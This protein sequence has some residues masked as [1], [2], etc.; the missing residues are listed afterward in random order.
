MTKKRQ[1]KASV[2]KSNNTFINQY[3][4]FFKK[5]PL[6]HSQPSC[7]N[8]IDLMTGYIQYRSTYAVRLDDI[9]SL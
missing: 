8:D 4:Y 1:H 7:D 5:L 6:N 3:E 9:T 2:S